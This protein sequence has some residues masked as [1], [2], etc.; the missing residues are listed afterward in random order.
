MRDLLIL[1]IHSLVTIT[2]LLRPG[3]VRALPAQSRLL[4]H[5]LLISNRCRGQAPN[6]TPLDHLVLGLSTL[7]L[8]PLQLVDRLA[9]PVPPPRIHRHRYFGVLART[10]AHGKF[11]RRPRTAGVGRIPP[12][13]EQ[14]SCQIGH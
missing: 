8:T 9:A 6:L 7:F 12:L 10:S 2:K 13:M 14:A 4:R 5:Q 3:G 11:P 1:A